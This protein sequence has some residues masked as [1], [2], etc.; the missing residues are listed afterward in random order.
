MGNSEVGHMTIGTG[1]IN[2][3]YPVEIEDM[4]NDGSFAKLAEF[5]NGIDHCRKNKSNLHLLQIF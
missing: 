2:K 3:Q 5:K 4:L 1:R